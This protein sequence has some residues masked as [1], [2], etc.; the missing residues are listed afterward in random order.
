MSTQYYP[1]IFMG[2]IIT[3]LLKQY[4]SAFYKLR[5]E[6]YNAVMPDKYSSKLPKTYEFGVINNFNLLMICRILKQVAYHLMMQSDSFAFPNMMDC[7]MM[8]TAGA[9]GSH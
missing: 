2:K 5:D 7:E 6:L 8:K 4:R 9:Q 1:H 3:Q